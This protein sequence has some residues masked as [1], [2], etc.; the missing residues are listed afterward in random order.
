[1][2]TQG[3]ILAR[4]EIPRSGEA[5]HYC[6]D[7]LA[8]LTR[9]T[10]RVLA[11]IEEYDLFSMVG[12]TQFCGDSSSSGSSSGISGSSTRGGDSNSSCMW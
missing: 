10:H 7:L 3:I 2:A 12:T 4:N 11:I 1:M 5:V 8:A 9:D 6:Y